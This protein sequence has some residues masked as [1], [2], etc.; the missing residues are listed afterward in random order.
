MKIHTL[1]TC[2][3]AFISLFM[4]LNAQEDAKN[5]DI[6]FEKTLTSR[7]GQAKKFLVKSYDA[8]NIVVWL[9]G[10]DVI[11][12]LNKLSDEDQA[13][14]LNRDLKDDQAMGRMNR[15]LSFMS[16]RYTREDRLKLIAQGGGK[17]EY[18]EQVISALSWMKKTQNI[19]GSW[20]AQ[21]KPVGMTGLALLAYLGHGETPVSPD[22]GLAVENAIIYL[23]KVGEKNRGKLTTSTTNKT[24]C[25]EHAIATYAL[26]EAYIACKAYNITIP[27]LK[28]T[29]M[30]AGHFIM[31]NQHKSGGWDY[32]YDTDGTRGGDTSTTSWHLQ[33]LMACKI[34]K[35]FD[36][37]TL[38]LSA[39]NGIKYLE[40]AKNGRGT[41]GYGTHGNN[42]ARGPTMTPGA[43]LCFQ[44]WGKGNRSFTRNAIIWITTTY[45]FNY[46]TDAN[47][48]MHYHSSHAMINAG[49][50]AW[51][52]YN[53]KTMPNLAAA[54]NEDGSWNLPGGA[55]HGL[56]SKHYATCLSTLMLESYYRFIPQ[57]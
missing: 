32:G 22:F 10:K 19:D 38:E 2:L 51:A 16:K 45:E 37:E 50:K 46:K 27:N 53:T 4:F 3:A 43:A 39:K 17:P 9:K 56:S 21:G 5:I 57:K 14:F 18:D 44:Q 55:S 33:A 52:D 28:E 25:Y 7:E 1:H 36:Q 48:Y 30:A 23:I 15:I 13:F 35:L 47:L 41:V 24:W 8:E 42:L 11:I 49:G 20:K 6:L 29:V 34:S 26:A 54:Q 40:G 12:P 31:D